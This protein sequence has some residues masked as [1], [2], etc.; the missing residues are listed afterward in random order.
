MAVTTKLFSNFPHF[1]LEDKVGEDITAGDALYIALVNDYAFDQEADDYWDDV[2]ADEAAGAGYDADGKA[3]A[4]VTCAMS[5]RVTT[6]DAADASWA[7]STV[8]ATGA[9]IRHFTGT[10]AT[11]LLMVYIDFDGSKAS[12]NGTFQ[13]TFHASGIFT[14]TVAA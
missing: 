1:L 2:V 4:S 6:V 13:I 12:D 7:S 14:L 3:L 9:V 8:T 10:D 11:D 5:T